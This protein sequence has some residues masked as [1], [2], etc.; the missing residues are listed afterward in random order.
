MSDQKQNQNP[1]NSSARDAKQMKQPTGKDLRS[2]RNILVDTETQTNLFYWYL[3]L[4]AFFCLIIGIV[5]LWGM[6]E[7]FNQILTIAEIEPEIKDIFIANWFETKWLI[8]VFIITYIISVAVLTF[9]Y[10][11]RM[12]GPSKAFKRHLKAMINGDF[13]GR[14]NLRK[15]DAFKEIAGLLN[16]LTNKLESEKKN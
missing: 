6:G 3:G 13:S 9:V 2:W 4:S 15:H 14:I 1:D 10:T 7:S 8:L 12:L 5:V 11:H 16:E